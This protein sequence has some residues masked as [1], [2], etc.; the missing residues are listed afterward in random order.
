MIK[1]ISAIATTLIL[2][3]VT[4]IAA[5]VMDAKTLD[6]RVQKLEGYSTKIDSDISNFKSD[7]KHDM[8][9]IK[10]Q[11]EIIIKLLKEEKK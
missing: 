6:N 1:W 4:Y 9:I 7:I 10:G 5:G 3:F 2:G 11:N 8:G